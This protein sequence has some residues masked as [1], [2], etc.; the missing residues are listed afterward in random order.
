MTKNYYKNFDFRTAEK[1]IKLAI[2]EDIGPG[3]ITSNKLILALSKS[4]ANVLLKEDAVIA[5]IKIFSLVCK[6]IDEKIKLKYF[7]RDGGFYKKGTIICEIS[8]NTR[9]ILAAERLSLNIIQRMSGIAT[10]VYKF[11][12][13]LGNNKVKILDTRK[14]TPNFRI[15]EKL[16]VKIGGGENH[17]M[18]LYDM[19]L[20]KDNHIAANG[21]IS[22]T[23][24]ALKKAGIKRELKIE[25]EVKSIQELDTVIKDGSGLVDI[26]MLDNFSISDTKKAVKLCGK[27]FKIEISGGV[28]GE[29]IRKYR[30]LNGI[31][32]ISSGSLT[33]S[34]RS[35]DIALDFIT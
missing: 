3:D 11:R 10:A 22:G 28:S 13:S 20:I 2:A 4:N 1:L 34:V 30:Y 35:V 12:K 9:S 8:G 24:S 19:V 7:A 17:R 18:G 27:K 26:V 21:G 16:A 23:L 33:H 15:F 14:T 29:N 32:Y 6:L 5:G 31:E 25:I